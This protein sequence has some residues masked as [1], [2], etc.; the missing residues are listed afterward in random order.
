MP[1][2]IGAIFFCERETIARV[3]P[4]SK[5]RYV[6]RGANGDVHEEA[7][8]HR[9]ITVLHAQFKS[10]EL[11]KKRIT[12]GI[13]APRGKSFSEQEANSP[14]SAPPIPGGVVGEIK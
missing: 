11:W 7:I 8:L 3:W 12:P 13:P 1:P 6:V 5:P 10:C 2:P 9:E 14:A 4:R